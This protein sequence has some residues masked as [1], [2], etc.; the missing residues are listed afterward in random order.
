VLYLYFRRALSNGQESHWNRT[1]ECSES[2]TEGLL[3]DQR[4]IC[5]RNL[6][7]MPVV[8]R[9]ARASIEVCQEL[10]A[11]RRWNC[12]SIQAAPNYMADLT[13]GMTSKIIIVDEGGDPGSRSNNIQL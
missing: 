3:K 1:S 10:F 9:A 4:L 5:R 2:R 13:G 11:D 8:S 7:L 6:E 12:S